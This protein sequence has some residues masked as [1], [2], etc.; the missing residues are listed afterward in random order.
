LSGPESSLE[1]AW[2]PPAERSDRNRTGKLPATVQL[3]LI[4][5][6]FEDMI[7]IYTAAAISDDHEDGMDDSKSY[8]AVTKSPLA[9]KW[10]TAMTEK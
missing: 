1:D 10:D 8:N 9:D 3:A 2:K 5:E 4:D 6:Q 7:P